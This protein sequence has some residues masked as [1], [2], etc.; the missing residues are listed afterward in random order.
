MTIGYGRLHDAIQMQNAKSVNA[1][2]SLFA[3]SV[4]E[5]L[6]ASGSAIN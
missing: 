4:T 6:I 1:N 2:W 3:K 5:R